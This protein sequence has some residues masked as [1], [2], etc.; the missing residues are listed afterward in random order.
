MTDAVLPA[1][2]AGEWLLGGE[3]PIARMGFGA[4][5]L[6]GP[7]SMGEPADRAEAKR[8]LERA[9][10]L[11]VTLVDTA[12][13]YGPGVSEE[14]VGEVLAGRGSGAGVVVATKGGYV[15]AGPGLGVANGAPSHIRA[16]CH[17]SLRRLGL[18]EIVLYQ[19]HAVDPAVPFEETVGA[20]VGLRDDGVVRHIGLSNVTLE[21]LRT[22]QALTPIAS[23]QNRYNLVDRRSDA[24]VD[25]CA[26]EGIAFLPWGPLA[27]D[28]ASAVAAVVQSVA[29]ECGATPAQ[30]VLAWALARS[31]AIVPI[32][33]TRR[34][35]H[36]DANVRAATVVLDP[37]QF[38]RIDTASRVGFAARGET[39]PASEIVY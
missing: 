13:C 2:E 12:D 6:T 20:F 21:Q 23:V 8:V 22:A 36:A 14:I 25:V 3:R 28:A 30:V 18:D 11:G 17:A 10:D 39:R 7:A 24:I 31:P 37:A 1:R 32:P 26:A 4:M 38:D 9:L 19:L 35:D 29:G 33:G 15:R 16:T 27:L 34:V 5:R